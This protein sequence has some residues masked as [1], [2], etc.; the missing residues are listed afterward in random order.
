MGFLTTVLVGLVVGLVAQHVLPGRDPGGWITAGVVGTIGGIVGELISRIT[1]VHFLTHWIP[2]VGFIV[3]EVL[4][5]V[6]GAVML[7]ALWRVY[8]RISRAG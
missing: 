2:V 7:L 6:V 3:R 5:G 4:F 8:R 1:G